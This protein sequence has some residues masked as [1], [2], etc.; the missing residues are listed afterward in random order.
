MTCRTT[1]D[2]DDRTC[3]TYT[4]EPSVAL[5]LFDVRGGDRRRCPSRNG[6][7]G[8]TNDSINSGIRAVLA[9]VLPD[10]RFRPVRP[11][12][13]RQHPLFLPIHAIRG[14]APLV[15]TRASLICHRPVIKPR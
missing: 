3:R 8:T 6:W 9:C 14:H 4:L 11:I 13:D 5:L 2:C 7:P 12:F 1:G 15:V 10:D